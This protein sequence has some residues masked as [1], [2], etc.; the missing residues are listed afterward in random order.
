MDLAA[1]VAEI[2]IDLAAS[3]IAADGCL[4]L[5]ITTCPSISFAP[6][7]LRSIVYNL[8]SNAI[9]YQRPG[10][11]PEVRLHCRSTKS[12]IVLEVQDNGL[13]LNEVQQGQLFGLFRR[14][15]DH[16][17]GSG[18]GLYMVKRMVENAG[19]N[20]AVRSE[21]GVGSTFIITLPAGATAE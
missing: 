10:C 17:D 14:L 5:D 7:N 9:K 13:G 20:I 15:H 11:P 1:L 16:V 18:I 19:G 8:L 4:T 2:R 12:T 3:L 6:Q 21:I